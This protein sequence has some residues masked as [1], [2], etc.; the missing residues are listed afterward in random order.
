MKLIVISPENEDSREQS[1]LAQLFAAGLTS[2]HLRK[3]TWSRDQLAAWLRSLPAEFHSRIVLHSHHELA[4]EFAV[5]GVHNAP[6]ATPFAPLRSHAVHSLVELGGLLDARARLVFSPVFP[7]FSKP[8]YGPAFDRD[9]LRTLLALPRRA[10]VIALGGIDATRI[11]AC[12]EFGFDGVAILGAVWQAADP[13]R[14]FA[15]LQNA[16]HAHAA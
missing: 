5:G 8:G 12:R 2:Y 10:E 7:S 6:T 4:A 3:P 14:A 16:L 13:V 9:E 1:V 11:Q 15:E